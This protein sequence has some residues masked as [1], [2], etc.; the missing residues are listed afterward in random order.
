MG[1]TG[2][3]LG[4]YADDI[5]KT[6]FR[7]EPRKMKD[8]GYEFGTTGRSVFTQDYGVLETITRIESSDNACSKAKAT[9]TARRKPGASPL[10][11]G[12][13]LMQLFA[14][15]FLE[16]IS[17]DLPPY[18]ETLLSVRMDGPLLLLTKP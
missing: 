17:P 6:L 15:V 10:L 4:G 7:L 18:E 1:L 9:K 3:L 2:T 12:Q 16:D 8:A 13:H 5:D 11:F 14:F